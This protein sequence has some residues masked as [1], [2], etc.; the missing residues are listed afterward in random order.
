MGV[1]VAATHLALGQTVALKFLR[2]ERVGAARDVARFVREARFAA[3]ITSSHVPRIL[4]AGTLKAG[5]VV[6][7]FIALEYLDGIDLA[8]VLARKGRLSPALAVAIVSQACE[9]LAEAHALGIVHRD[10]KPANLFLGV[11]RRGLE[12]KVL[13]FG[14]AKFRSDHDAALTTTD[15]V[16]GSP[17]YMSPEQMR[18]ASGVDGRADLWSLGVILFEAVSGALPFHS[19]VYAEL[20]LKVMLDPVPPLPEDCPQAFADVIHRCLEKDPSRRFTSADELRDALA[21]FAGELS[22][23]TLAELF[24][25]PGALDDHPPSGVSAIGSN[26]RRELDAV[27]ATVT[28]VPRR[29]RR[30]L[31]ASLLGAAVALGAGGWTLWPEGVEPPAP[32]VPAVLAPSAAPDASQPRAIAVSA[33]PDAAPAPP[34]VDA[35]PRRPPRPP[36][37]R[38]PR[39]PPDKAPVGTEAQPEPAWDPLA[40]PY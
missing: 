21:P 34:T 28:P 20:C 13:D 17:A 6:A 3:R 33:T 38:R 31:V 16:V 1:V 18:V 10:V 7:P 19:S 29:R 23:A 37:R 24:H 39:R 35:A 26:T 27:G 9:A 40:S 15:G 11:S 12:V 5:G 30:V 32:V 36:P 2:R 4:D 14:V 8:R 22:E 25:D